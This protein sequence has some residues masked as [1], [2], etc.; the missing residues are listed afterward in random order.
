MSETPF[1]KRA[2]LGG[3]AWFLV[4]LVIAF[5]AGR[6]VFRLAANIWER[7]HHRLLVPIMIIGLPFLLCFT[8]LFVGAVW[9]YIK[10]PK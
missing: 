5:F 8:W 1:D 2:A 4:F 6:E 9:S 10:R 7:W 3:F